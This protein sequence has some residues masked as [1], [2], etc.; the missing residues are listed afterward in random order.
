MGFSVAAPVAWADRYQEQIDKLRRQNQSSEGARTNLQ[1][2]A[3]SLEETIAALRAEI[4]AVE[5]QIGANQAKRAE[6]ARKIKQ[7]ETQ[8]ARERNTL[9]A[10]IKQMYVDSDM[11]TL[12]M[13]ASS[14]NLSEYIDRDQYRI[15][16]QDKI[17]ATMERIEQLKNKLDKQKKTIE[18][19]LKDQQQMRKTLAAKRTENNRLLSLNRSQQ[20]AFNKNIS[21]NNGRIAELQRQQAIENARH[22]IGAISYSGSGGY[23]WASVPFPNSM[24][25]P[26]GM[27]KRQCVSYTAWKVSSTGRHM[28]YWG[29]RGNANLWD[30]NARAAGIPVDYN[31]RPGDVGVSNSGTYGHV[32]YVERVHGD[33]TITVSQYNAGWDGRYSVV[34]RST[35]GLVFI[36]F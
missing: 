20:A 13:L 22:N 10:N 35:A 5:A 11:S 23:P 9:G 2:G 31:P 1:A 36:H 26:W 24:P 7:F 4:A 3:A 15:S 12:E 25:D 6:L 17:T 30:D 32:V 8:L 21:A 16:V 14:K 29:G 27:Y 34:R 33:G 18:K 28:P 19:L